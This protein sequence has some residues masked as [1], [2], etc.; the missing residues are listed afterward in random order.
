MK[1][2]NKIFNMST[3]GILLVVFGVVIGRATFVE[4]DFGTPSAKA[5]I[6]NSWWFEGLMGLMMINMIVIIFTHKLYRKEKLVSFIFHVAFITIILGAA[7]TRYVGYEGVI[8]IR[9]GES[10]NVFVSDNVY[11]TVMIEKGDQSIEDDQ[12]VLFSPLS[13]GNYN[14]SF[15][16]KE[17]SFDIT[18]T[19]YIPHAKYELLTDPEG[20][21]V[22][23]L[24]TSGQGGRVDKYLR[25]GHPEMI[26]DMLFSLNGTEGEGDIRIIKNDTGFV[27]NSPVP[28]RY[29][30]M[31]DQSMGT[32]EENQWHPFEQRQLYVAGGTSFVYKDYNPHARLKLT[33]TDD[34][35]ST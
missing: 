5:V 21:P 13:G 32:L 30:K 10:S 12:K 4:N 7:V 19:E 6:Y 29:M 33:S 14:K 35:N 16:V 9:E 26:G 34:K 24:V 23:T 31:A 22:L 18:L 15:V 25:Q 20:G 27:F 2:L 11:V 3:T 8:H 17:N 28:L 1:I